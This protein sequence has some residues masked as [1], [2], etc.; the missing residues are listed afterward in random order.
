VNVWARAQPTDKVA[1]VESLSKQDHITVMTGDG[2]NDA[3]ALKHAKTG[4][5]MGISGTEVAKNAASLVLMD[6]DFSTIVAAIREGRRIYAN[7]QKYLLFN[8]CLKEGELCAVLFALIFRLPLPIQGL[9]QLVNLICTHVAPPLVLAYEQPEPYLMDIPPRQT[10]RDFIVT[11]LM[12]V[13]RWVPFLAFMTVG[14][15]SCMCSGLWLQTGFISAAALVGTS[16]VGELDRGLV[17]CEFAGGLDKDR[18]FIADSAPFHCK[19]YNSWDQVEVDQWGSSHIS[20]NDV[21]GKFD[22]WT[23]YVSNV[24]N[25]NAS[26][27]ANGPE[28][29]VKP[30]YDSAQVLHNCW[31]DD[32]NPLLK[33]A[34]KGRPLLSATHNCASYGSRIGETT[35]YAAIQMGEVFSLINF[36]TDGSIAAHV[37]TNPLYLVAL[38]L[39]ISALCV[40]LYVPAVAN[41]LQFAPLRPAQFA[42]AF[43]FALMLVLFN[44]IVKR[45]YMSRLK[46]MHEMESVASQEE[47]GLSLVD[48]SPSIKASSHDEA[49]DIV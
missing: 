17:A 21:L 25:K 15:L 5:A 27:W 2:V 13:F 30:C 46:A 29:F 8:F 48:N 40:M 42:M 23:G 11:P 39:N 41:A 6:D 43:S 49:T 47:L 9:Q 1:I 26:D 4:V 19:C 37:F 35:G 36:R 22:R 12:M 10:K 20:E 18:N 16:R 32:A 14:V 44:E 38:A 34:A 3:P 7:T 24:Y 28:S 45:L 33:S 31:N